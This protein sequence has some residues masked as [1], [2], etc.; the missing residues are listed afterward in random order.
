MR[1][2]DANHGRD[3]R[4]LLLVKRLVNNC[5]VG[6]LHIARV[7]VRLQLGNESKREAVRETMIEHMWVGRDVETWERENK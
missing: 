1:L 3:G 6:Q 4:A 7:H 2:V 5:A